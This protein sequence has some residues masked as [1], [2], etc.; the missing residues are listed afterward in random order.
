MIEW[1]KV[2]WYSKLGAIIFFIAVLPALSFYIGVKYEQAK[3]ANTSISSYVSVPIKN[4]GVDLKKYVN[5]KYEFSF[6]YPSDYKV[7][8]SFNKAFDKGLVYDS[9][10]AGNK[11]E[12]EDMSRGEGPPT[13]TINVFSNP[14]NLSP[15]EWIRANDPGGNFKLAQMMAGKETYSFRE[16]A[17][18]EALAFEGDGLYHN[19]Y[20]VFNKNS[21][22]YWISISYYS[23]NESTDTLL[24]THNKILDSL[25]F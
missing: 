15:L 12:L 2:T 4:I 9:I 5:E 25:S 21:N 24:E 1:N 7:I 11:K 14:E 10:T 22:L 13:F 20:L 19:K 16:F 18:T 6:E 8:E 3:V 17:G 23:P